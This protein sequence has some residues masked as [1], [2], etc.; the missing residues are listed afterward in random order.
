MRSYQGDHSVTHKLN[1]FAGILMIIRQLVHKPDD[2]PIWSQC[3]HDPPWSIPIKQTSGKM[4]H[5]TVWDL[6]VHVRNAIGHPE[7]YSPGHPRVY[8]WNNVHELRGFDF[9]CTKKSCLRLSERDM[10]EMS[11]KIVERLLPKIRGISGK[12]GKHA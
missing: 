11:E 2:D 7:S 8:P 9:Y 4:V 3:I 10:L 6:I 5:A 1:C 12:G